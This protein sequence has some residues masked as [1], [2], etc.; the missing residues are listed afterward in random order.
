MRRGERGAFKQRNEM[1][2]GLKGS[3]RHQQQQQQEEKRKENKGFL[4]GNQHT[5]TT[6]TAKN[7]THSLAH[8]TNANHCSDTNRC[9][10]SISISSLN[11]NP[12]KMMPM[13]NGARNSCEAAATAATSAA[14][15]KP[16]L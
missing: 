7:S 1:K 10:S 11:E 2:R 5:D 6:Q 3:L 15:M 12:M 13:S 14:Q 16:E 8:S 4:H 9:S